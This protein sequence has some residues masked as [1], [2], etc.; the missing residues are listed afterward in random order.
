MI[1][2]SHPTGNENVRQAALAFREAGLLREF[3]T[4]IS[5]NS[6]AT[7]SGLLPHSLRQQLSRRSFHPS[8]RAVTRT[9]PAREMGRLLVSALGLSIFSE[10]ET[11]PLSIDAIFSDL[12]RK[13]AARLSQLPDCKLVYAYEDGALETFRAAQAHS[14]SRVYDLP[15]GY[16][17]VAQQIYAEERERE[18]AWAAT[19]TGVRDSEE[20]L[21]RKDEE[22]RLADR[23]VVASSFTKETLRAADLA[24]EVQVIPYG[25]PAAISA[26]VEAHSGALR[27]LFVGSL[28]QRKGLSYLLQAIKLLGSKV[29]L[30]LLGRKAV[31]GCPPL[32]E[33]IRK[34]RWIPS[35]PHPE[36]LRVMQ[37]HDVLILP[38]LFEGFGLV[39][40]E[41]M[42]QRLPV[43][44]TPHTAGPDVISEGVDGFIVPI[45]SAE[46][47]AARL[48]HLA[49]N[50]N[51]LQQMKQ[52]AQDKAK[53]QRWENYRESLTQ[54]AQDLVFKNFPA[55]H[56][57]RA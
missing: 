33:A 9:A 38:S 32:E 13:V 11:G 15:I 17:K 37:Q 28:G 2:L 14:I 51:L 30:T 48:D 18:P 25:A 41:A 20:K 50:P 5:W 23:V 47:I 55:H 16:W 22:L 7:V 6:N 39:I 35:L 29:E 27:V 49:S 54:M 56:G 52:A 12:D 45:R 43:I 36:L 31:D 26:N 3:W 24:V 19:L 40:L 57:I 34:H 53:S 8:L 10:H 21:A 42:A 46:A 4:C 1:L 44:A